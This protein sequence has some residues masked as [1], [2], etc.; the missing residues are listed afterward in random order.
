MDEEETQFRISYKG[1]DFDYYAREGGV[2]GHIAYLMSMGMAMQPCGY[3]NF[4]LAF[5][6]F[7][8]KALHVPDTS[9]TSDVAVAITSKSEVE[10][11]KALLRLFPIWA[12]SLVFGII[13]AQSSTFFTKQ[14]ATLDRSLGPNFDIPPASLQ[15]FGAIC[16]FIFIPIYDCLLVPFARN[17]TGKHSSI[18]VLQRIGTGLF[19]SIVCM[20]IAAIT[21][22]RRLDIALHYGLIDLPNAMVPMSIWWL[23]PQSAIS[24]I[25]DAF[26]I[27]GLQEFFYDQVPVELRS[28]GMSLYLTVLG[29]GSLLSSMLVSLVDKL[30]SAL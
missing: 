6:R 12:T 25:A 29:I 13:F 20:V 23:L 2:N 10:E 24:G 28:V 30:S 7:L 5:L 26:T 16:I 3:E 8:D 22:K 27:V 21:E 11:A 14:A 1:F 9:D 15:S 19:L 18:S 4:E 17:L